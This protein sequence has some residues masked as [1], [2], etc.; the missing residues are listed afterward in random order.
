MSDWLETFASALR[1]RVGGDAPSLNI[2][3][4]AKGPVLSL[5]RVVA[6]GTERKNAPLATYLVGKYVAGRAS[7]GVDET[8][9]LA[10]ALQ[11]AEALV[12]PETRA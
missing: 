1:G 3:R 10:E 4:R 9:A 7:A 5:A 8:T 6:H 12:P 2:T 11:E